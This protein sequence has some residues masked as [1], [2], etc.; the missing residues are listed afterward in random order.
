MLYRL[1]KNY[2]T[3]GAQFLQI[4]ESLVIYYIK[5]NII[6]NIYNMELKEIVLILLVLASMFLMYKT[7]DLEKFESSIGDASTAVVM[8]KYKTD[9]N[10]I[11]NISTFMKTALA[12]PNNDSFSIKS[13]DLTL[14]NLNLDGDLIVNGNVLFSTDFED[15][16][17]LDLFPRFMIMAWNNNITGNYAASVPRG[18][19]PCDGGRYYMDYNGKSAISLSDDPSNPN[20]RI[21]VKT[22]NLKGRFIVGAGKG[23][24]VDGTQ[25]ASANVYT[26]NNSDDAPRLADI[27]FGSYGGTETHTLTVPEL[28]IHTHFE[29][30]DGKPPPG[31]F[32]NPPHD[33]WPE[34]KKMENGNCSGQQLWDLQPN[35]NHESDYT[36]GDEKKV[37][38]PHNNMPP[39]YTLIYI[40]KL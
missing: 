6:Y 29:T 21:S 28:P 9:L 17:L 5:N 26:F 22:P 16:F 24:S 35:W 37:T 23:F 31:D 11:K 4:R 38:K 18:W 10:A 2:T 33:P 3:N 36:G 25:E 32:Y 39:Y 20:Y 30:N 8:N 34:Y 7:R 19:A 12:P 27:K 14:N 1:Y 13:T 15:N 40:M